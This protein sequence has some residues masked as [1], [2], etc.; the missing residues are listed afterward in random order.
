MTSPYAPRGRD[1]GLPN[2]LDAHFH[3][4]DR[5]IIDAE[6]RMVAKVD[7]LELQER[8]DG[9]V[10]TAILT[11]PGALGPRLG[12]RLGEWMVATWKRLH[13]EADPRPGRIPIDTIAGVDSAVHVRSRRADLDVEGFERW[14]DDRIVSRLPF[15][16][17][18]G[19]QWSSGPPPEPAPASAAP[20]RLS[21][22]IGQTVLGA[23]GT[24]LG[25]VSDVRLQRDPITDGYVV[26]ELLVN[27]NKVRSRFG[28]ERPAAELPPAVRWLLRLAGSP[29]AGHLSWT[30]VERVDWDARQVHCRVA[31]LQHF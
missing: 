28:Y 19:P 13:H 31:A 29:A 5:Q 27:A 3:L 16:H 7:D 25:R 30:E 17:G 6:D 23:D 11:G 10:V 9:F 26:T 20:R 24:A 8:F 1:T 22:L 4:L 14:A 21:T 12:G 2:E 15:V 18:R